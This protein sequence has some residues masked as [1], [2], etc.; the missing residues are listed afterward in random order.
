MKQTENKY[1]LITSKFINKYEKLINMKHLCRHQLKKIFINTY[2]QC[3][4]LV[5]RRVSLKVVRINPNAPLISEFQ[6]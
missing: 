5:T 3:F 4:K 6:C 1:K 2:V